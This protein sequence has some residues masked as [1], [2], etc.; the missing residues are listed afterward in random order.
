VIPPNRPDVLEAGLDILEEFGRRT[1]VRGRFVALYLGLRLMGDGMTPLGAPGATRA[2]EIE[3]FLD[4]MWAK[5]HRPEPLV[6]L[7]APFGGST[8]PTAPYST[9]SG[10]FA[11]GHQY[12]TNTWRNNFNIQKGI[13]CPAEPQV[14]DRLLR[15]PAVRLACPHMQTDPE[16]RYVCGIAGTAYRGEEHSIWLHMA[17]DGYQ[18]VDLNLPAVHRP[19]LRP[20]DEPIPLFPL[21]AAL[22]CLSPADVYPPRQRVGIPDFGLDF[23]FAVEQVEELFDCDPESPANAALLTLVEGVPVPPPPA[24]PLPGEE[25]APGPLPD[26]PPDAVLN[27]GVGAELAVAAQLGR[28]GWEVRYRGNQRGLGYDL[29]AAHDGHTLRVEVKSSVAFTNPELREAE[30]EAAQRYGDEYVLAVVDFYGS[31][32]QSIWYVRDP[33]AA[34]I[35]VERTTTIFRLVRG[36]IMAVR[37]E[38]EF[39]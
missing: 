23:G 17:E 30:W 20:G 27:T 12:P 25:P 11:P 21:I 10:E 16:G 9:R 24:P 34:A 3:G 18:V 37:T 39:L 8:S 38:A 26:L 4:R 1:S 36:D 28:H 5:T 15:N 35:P 6:V 33:A 2:H 7:T 29:E 32:E 13:G 19:Y 14:I 31:D 22:Y